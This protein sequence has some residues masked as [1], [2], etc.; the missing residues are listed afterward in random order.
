MLL[1]F[2]TNDQDGSDDVISGQ[3]NI[4]G[5]NP[6]FGFDDEFAKTKRRLK[7]ISETGE[8]CTVSTVSKVDFRAAGV[9][10]R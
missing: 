1:H 7:L 6:N 9:E 3:F 10:H 2:L 4:K 5:V 8:I